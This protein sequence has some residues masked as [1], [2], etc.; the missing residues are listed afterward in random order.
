MHRFYR[1]IFH[2]ATN[3]KIITRITLRICVQNI[4]RCVFVISQSQS[5][6]SIGNFPYEYSFLLCTG[7]RKIWRWKLIFHEVR[8]QGV[9]RIALGSFIRLFNKADY[10]WKEASG[11][12]YS[13]LFS[14]TPST[15]NNFNISLQ[16]TSWLKSTGNFV[17]TSKLTIQ[18]HNLPRI[19]RSKLRK[20]L[21]SSSKSCLPISIY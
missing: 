2:I 10:V 16:F 14:I 11:K 19:L 17:S 3:Y 15:N 20:I 5:I 6:Y 18:P 4:L 7:R 21:L 1:S 9:M 8:I 12:M 13:L